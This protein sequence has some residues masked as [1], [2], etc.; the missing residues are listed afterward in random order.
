[1][2]YCGEENASYL[3]TVNKNKEFIFT[4]INQDEQTFEYLLSNECPFKVKRFKND[5]TPLVSITM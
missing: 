4:R 5:A 1:M 2:I 3:C